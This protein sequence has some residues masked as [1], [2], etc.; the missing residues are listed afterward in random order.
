MQKAE[1]EKS[2]AAGHVTR[3]YRYDYLTPAFPSI[4]VF[5]KKITGKSTRKG[6]NFQCNFSAIFFSE[7]SYPIPYL[8]G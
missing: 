6:G 7:T 4:I 1:K 3:I 5:W 8:S 2:I